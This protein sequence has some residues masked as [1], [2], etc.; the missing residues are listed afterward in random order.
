MTR[1]SSGHQIIIFLS[2]NM[3]FVTA[4]IRE[5]GGGDGHLN[6]HWPVS[7]LSKITCTDES[8]TAVTY[9]STWANRWILPAARTSPN[10]PALMDFR[11]TR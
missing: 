6:G 7:I 10:E 11:F 8:G 5:G 9:L 1:P 4:F 2:E 3:T